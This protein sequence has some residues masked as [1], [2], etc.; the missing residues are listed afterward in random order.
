MNIRSFNRYSVKTEQMK[1]FYASIPI[2]F[3]LP[4]LFPVIPAKGL[5]AKVAFD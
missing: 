4:L 5:V 1:I 3:I 2:A